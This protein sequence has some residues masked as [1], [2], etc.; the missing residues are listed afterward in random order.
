MNEKPKRPIYVADDGIAGT[1]LNAAGAV[2][3]D[4][5]DDWHK[6]EVLPVL[7]MA[8]QILPDSQALGECGRGCW[9]ELDD[10]VQTSVM[11]GRETI[12]AL[13]AQLEGK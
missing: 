12:N 1:A 8:R 10:D 6:T 9:N 4:A 2:Y 5:M 3:A 13:V 11:E 7:R